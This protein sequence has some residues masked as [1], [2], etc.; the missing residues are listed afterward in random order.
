MDVKIS[1]QGRAYCK[2]KA[3][4]LF[5]SWLWRGP[6]FS[7][8]AAYFD[9][10]LLADDKGTVQATLGELHKRWRVSYQTVFS[11]LAA[12]NAHEYIRLNYNY[13]TRVYSITIL[14]VRG[15]HR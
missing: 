6:K 3:Q 12:L 15:W 13:E 8:H 11:W 14:D 4:D 7:I 1:K 10:L 9:L 2:L 5:T